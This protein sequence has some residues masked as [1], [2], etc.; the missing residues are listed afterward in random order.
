MARRS[1][2][3]EHTAPVRRRSPAKTPEERESI[4]ISKSLNLIEKQI[5]DGTAS[6]Q[7]LSIYAKYGSQRER[8]EQE[9]L[10]NENE[11]LRKKVETMEAAVDVKN[12]MSDALQAFRGYSGQSLDRDDEEDDYFD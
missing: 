1:I 12:L 7:I 11:V 10:R 8:L 5:D 6:S 9:R 4:L 3:D 2:D